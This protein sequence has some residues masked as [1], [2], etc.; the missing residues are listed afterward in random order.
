MRFGKD[1][2]KKYK[3]LVYAVVR[4]YR[5]F[6]PQIDSEELTAEGERGL[7]EASLK[8]KENCSAAFS[9]YAWYRV[10][11][12]VQ[13]YISKNIA[14]IEMPQSARKIFASVKKIIDDEAKSGR[15]ADISK[16][17]KLLNLK[18]SEISDA[19][20]SDDNILNAVSLDK[21]VDVGDNKKPLAELI[22]DK[23]QKSIFDSLSQNEDMSRLESMM[24]GLSENEKNVL[25]YRFGLGGKTVQK[26][27]LKYISEK[28][29]LSVSKVKDLEKNALI[30]LRGMMK[31]SDE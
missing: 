6:F 7:F 9:T 13:E 24:S 26:V 10:V 15:T 17:A 22:E 31:N 1:E 29:G 20:V 12:N 3:P 11:K 21:E 18:R 14:I 25:S 4:K 2:I 16:I 8:Y 19:M 30:K 5:T 28:L 23:S 27:S